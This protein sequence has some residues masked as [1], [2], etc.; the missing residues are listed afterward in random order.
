M[1]GM[2]EL[3]L[4]NL[5]R[6]RAHVDALGTDIDPAQREA[7]TAG[8]LFNLP[9]PRNNGKFVKPYNRVKDV[10]EPMR[11]HETWVSPRDYRRV[12]RPSNPGD[13]QATRQAVP[14]YGRDWTSVDVTS[15]H[16]YRI[17]VTSVTRKQGDIRICCCFGFRPTA[18]QWIWMLNALCFLAHS[19]MIYATLWFAYFRHERDWLTETEHLMIPI[20]RIRTVPTRYMLDNNMSKWSEGWNLTSSE[21]NSGLF[22]YE[23]GLPINFASLII[24]FFATSALFHFWALVFGAFE[25]TWFWYWR[26]AQIS[27]PP[28]PIHALLGRRRLRPLCRIRFLHFHFLPP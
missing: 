10:Q 9:N 1:P 3:K 5:K 19:F 2:R 18:A 28:R 24:A 4:L 15:V 6:W 11:G 22:L 26:C 25:R 17:P 27:N 16:K 13:W 21:Q 7:P 8:A 23:N 20:Y 14:Q 12:D